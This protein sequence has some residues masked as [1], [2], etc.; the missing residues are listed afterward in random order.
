[1]YIRLY[2]CISIFRPRYTHRYLHAYL[3][4]YL[5]RIITSKLPFVFQPNIGAVKRPRG[6]ILYAVPA[7]S[8]DSGSRSP[9]V[10]ARSSTTPFI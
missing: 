9:G 5:H 10:G 8:V 2:I 6:E 1:M 7:A 3:P 4:T